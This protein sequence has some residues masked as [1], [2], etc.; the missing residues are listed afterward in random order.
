[1]LPQAMKGEYMTYT[2]T[3]IREKLATDKRWAIRGLLRL[4]SFQT[5]TEKRFETT[6]QHNGRGFGAADAPFLTSLA[7]QV[8]R[9]QGLYHIGPQDFHPGLLTN[10]QFDALHKMLPKYGGQLFRAIEKKGAS[11]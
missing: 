3:E 2:E 9:K 7:K 8:I 10:P 6:A 1:M 11:V 4:Y 5:E